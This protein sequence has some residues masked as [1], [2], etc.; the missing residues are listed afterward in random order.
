MA[1]PPAWRCL[2]RRS[3]PP[4]AKTPTPTRAVAPSKTPTLTRSATP[5]RTPMATATRAAGSALK[6]TPTPAKTTK[7]ASTP[8]RSPTPKLDG[9]AVARSSATPGPGVASG[10][11]TGAGAADDS[12]QARTLPTPAD[13]RGSTQT[14]PPVPP[15][16]SAD[17]PASPGAFPWQT[18]GLGALGL[19]LLA[20]GGTLLHNRHHRSRPDGPDVTS[21][22]RSE[23]SDEE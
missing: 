1:G 6:K 23:D 18:L 14:A 3:L 13:R 16:S 19:A 5:S 20:G 17:P 12:A 22:P 11:A 15:L 2:L 10:P 4:P 8:A 9:S 7:A 21:Y